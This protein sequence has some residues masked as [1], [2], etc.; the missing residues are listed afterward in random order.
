MSYMNYPVPHLLGHVNYPPGTKLRPDG[1]TIHLFN[2]VLL[3]NGQAIQ[4][5]NGTF[6]VA[7]TGI[8]K[9]KIIRLAG[10]P[11]AYHVPIRF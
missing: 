6:Q 1:D 9:P 8:V 4:P 5:T 3:V 2:P 7:V 11:G 10:K